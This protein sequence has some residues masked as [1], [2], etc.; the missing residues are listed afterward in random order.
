MFHDGSGAFSGVILYIMELAAR[1]VGRIAQ[2]SAGRVDG[3]LSA[4]PDSVAALEIV[5]D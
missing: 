4:V 5:L 2:R 3:A 1:R